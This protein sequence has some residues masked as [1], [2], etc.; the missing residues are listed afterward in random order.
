MI[1]GPTNLVFYAP[2]QPLENTTLVIT[3]ILPLFE[4]KIMGRLIDLIPKDFVS[5]TISSGRT[6]KFEAEMW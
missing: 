2:C 5:L 4:G 1:N 6:N 3:V